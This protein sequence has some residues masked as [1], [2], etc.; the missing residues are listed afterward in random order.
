MVDA[1]EIGRVAI[2][3]RRRRAERGWTLDAAAARLGVSRRLLAQ[4][5]AGETNPSLSSLLSI[6]AGFGVPLVALLAEAHTPPIT[7]QDDNGSAHV[8]WTGPAG[9]EGRLL[10]ASGGLELWEWT[11]QPGEERRSDAHRPGAR[12]ALTV[13]AGSVT[14][15]VA[16]AE[17]ATLRR[18]QSAAFGADVHH[19]YAN[20]R[21]RPARFLLAVHEAS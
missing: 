6:A 17:P 16:G 18:G 10:V 12:E 4:I 13:T 9:G 3:V 8:L 2:E 21:E 19:R 11:L 7:I 14:I 15:E 5:E 20:E 1:A